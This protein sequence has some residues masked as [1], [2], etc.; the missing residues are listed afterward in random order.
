MSG[1]GF[2]VYASRYKMSRHDRFGLWKVGECSNEFY[3]KRVDKILQ[4]LMQPR[5]SFCHKIHVSD[6]VL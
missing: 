2:D 1:I 4:N 5:K 6:F 3:F